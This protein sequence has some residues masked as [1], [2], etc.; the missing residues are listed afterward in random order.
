M[1]MSTVLE[2]EKAIDS[3]PPQ[4]LW[5]LI[6]WVEQKRDDAEDA[7]DVARAEAILAE[8]NETVSWEQAKAELG[9]K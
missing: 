5:K 1:L 7:Y 4:E 2:I 3:L 9:W 8:G 6:Q